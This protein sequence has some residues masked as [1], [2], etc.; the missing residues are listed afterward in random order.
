MKTES[1]LALIQFLQFSDCK[2][3]IKNYLFENKEY[4]IKNYSR[5]EDNL[6]YNFI[7]FGE[8][9]ISILNSVIYK[10]EIK[11]QIMRDSKFPIR[12]F[13]IQS[14]WINEIL[15]MSFYDFLI[16]LKENKV[17]SS[18]LFLLDTVFHEPIVRISKS[19]MIIEFS[20]NMPHMFDR[21]FLHFDA[22]N[23][24]GNFGSIP[25]F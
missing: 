14:N 6:E 2:N 16:F 21:I 24:F 17:Y 20:E 1:C 7:D 10:V 22:N 25:I 15:L 12:I 13:G 8:L 5:N 23:P 18:R 9:S 4:A 19:D 11:P 3:W